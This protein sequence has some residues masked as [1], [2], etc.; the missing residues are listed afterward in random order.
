MM[1]A[2]G[3]TAIIWTFAGVFAAACFAR[4][5]KMR[6]D[7]RVLAELLWYTSGAAF[8]AGGALLWVSMETEILIQHRIVLATVG[9]VFGALALL[10]LGELLPTHA[11]TAP[12]R[13]E[14]QLVQDKS[15]VP[16]IINQNITTNNQSGGTNTNIV[17][18]SP[19]IRRTMNEALK[20]AFLKDLPKDK[21]ILVMGMSG[22]TE[23]MAFANEIWTFLKANGY[24]VKNDAAAWHMFFNPPVFNAQISPGE[25]G[26]EWWIVVG[27]AE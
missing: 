20:A 8:L 26:K 18:V 16:P 11:Q 27:P 15:G 17:N 3:N 14:V 1:G 22:N 24:P 21:P 12:P 10:S 25:G 13:R 2:M 19:K 4:G 9:A 6:D 7:S 23:S 5:L